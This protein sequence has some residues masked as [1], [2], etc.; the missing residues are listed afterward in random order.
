[1]HW[2]IN[3]SSKYR[4]IG[5]LSLDMEEDPLGLSQ[6]P[7]PLLAPTFWT[8]SVPRWDQKVSEMPHGGRNKNSWELSSRWNSRSA[9]SFTKRRH[10]SETP[11][12]NSL[13]AFSEG[14]NDD[15]GV[16]RQ[17]KKPNDWC[18]LTPVGPSIEAEHFLQLPEAALCSRS[19]FY[20]LHPSP[21]LPPLPF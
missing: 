15:A 11:E 2:H 19:S 10:R 14:W 16:H 18:F 17:L 6:R 13:P 20:A 8:W 12:V 7:H 21:Q 9:A 5:C 3:L 4:L 1:M